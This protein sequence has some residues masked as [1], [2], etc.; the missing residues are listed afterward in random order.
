MEQDMEQDMDQ[1][2]I[3]DMEQDMDQYVIPEMDQELEQDMDQYVRPEMEQEMDQYVRPDMEQEFE[4]QVIPEME[5]RVIPQVEKHIRPD[6]RVKRCT[7]VVN[8]NILEWNYQSVKCLNDLIIELGKPTIINNKSGGLAIWTRQTLKKK[9]YC[10]T[11]VEVHDKTNM[12]NNLIYV[13]INKN[14]SNKNVKDILALSNMI[15]YNSVKQQLCVKSNSMGTIKA[16][17]VLACYIADCNLTLNDARENY[18][19]FILSTKEGTNKYDPTAEIMFE[20]II[21]SKCIN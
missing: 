1:Y 11:R 18:R 17:M 2:V 6:T 19:D 14:I 21:C 10:W 15:K 12:N 7:E 8:N 5:Q 4:Q 3:P 13:W 9:N 16:I 20:Q